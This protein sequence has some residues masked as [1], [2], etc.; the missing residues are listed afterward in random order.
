V[1][2]E[3]V[4]NGTAR[5]TRT[6]TGTGAATNLTCS[7]TLSITASHHGLLADADRNGTINDLDR[8]GKDK[9]SIARGA[10]IPPC[11]PTW[12]GPQP[13]PLRAIVDSFCG[14]G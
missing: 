3:A 12:G 14:S 5:L 10:L 2:V 4:S 6:F 7:G 8:P 11:T 9:W 13:N 1:R